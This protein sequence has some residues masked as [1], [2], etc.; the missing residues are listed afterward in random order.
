MGNIQTTYTQQ[1]Q[2]TMPKTNNLTKIEDT[3]SLCVW[4]D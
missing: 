2:Y 1:H 3:V 4:R